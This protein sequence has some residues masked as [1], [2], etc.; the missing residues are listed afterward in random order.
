MKNH[1]SYRFL[2]LPRKIQTSLCSSR[3]LSPTL[4]CHNHPQTLLLV[5]PSMRH[6]KLFPPLSRLSIQVNPLLSPWLNGLNAACGNRYTVRMSTWSSRAH[7]PQAPTGR[8]DDLVYI[9]SYACR[10]T[11]D[12][13][14][15]SHDTGN[16]HEGFH[17]DNTTGI[18]F[19][20]FRAS[21]YPSRYPFHEALSII[22]RWLP[23]SYCRQCS[24]S[25]WQ[26]YIGQCSMGNWFECIAPRDLYDCCIVSLSI[27]SSLASSHQAIAGPAG[28][29]FSGAP[30]TVPEVDVEVPNPNPLVD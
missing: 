14:P 18:F 26:Y 11:L 15:F 4:S 23:R 16:T 28:R 2:P 12:C 13:P 21:V 5:A 22:L 7:K 9:S 24:G 29:F 27:E 19:P 17:C 30:V 1:F 20:F 3:M 8:S 6:L 25:N 10:A